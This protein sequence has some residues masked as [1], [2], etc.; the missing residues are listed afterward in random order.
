MPLKFKSSKNFKHQRFIFQICNHCYKFPEQLYDFTFFHLRRS[1]I[2]ERTL[3][4]KFL[5]MTTREI[6]DKAVHELQ[7][8]KKIEKSSYSIVKTN[9]EIKIGDVT[10]PIRTPKNP[11]LVPEIVFY[12]MPMHVEVS[13]KFRA[14]L[15]V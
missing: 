8:R 3:M 15:C 12:E 13:T 10:A 5:P 2:I 9:T 4:S 7:L 6:L 14:N 1:D 11:A